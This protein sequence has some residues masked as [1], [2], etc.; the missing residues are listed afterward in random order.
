MVLPDIDRIGTHFNRQRNF[1]NHVARIC[2]NHAAA[3]DLAVAVRFWRIIKQQLGDTFV[4]A[5][6][7]GAAGCRPGEQ[8]FLTFSPKAKVK[9]FGHSRLRDIGVGLGGQKSTL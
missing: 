8:A 4:A 7:D 5:I 1:P 2:A 6:G 9:V 3:Q